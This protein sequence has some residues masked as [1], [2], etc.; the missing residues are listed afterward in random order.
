MDRQTYQIIGELKALT[1]V[2]DTESAQVLNYLKAARSERALLV[3]FGS[4]SLQHERSVW[5][6]DAAQTPTP[7]SR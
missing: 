1:R 6:A 3:N 4:R 2:G 7:K 5:S